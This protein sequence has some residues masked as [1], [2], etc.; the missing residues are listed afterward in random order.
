MIFPLVLSDAQA[1]IRGTA[2]E[3]SVKSTAST[4]ASQA[5]RAAPRYES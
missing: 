3:S 2:S 5:P 1:F 4:V